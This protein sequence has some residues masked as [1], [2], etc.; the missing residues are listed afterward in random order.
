LLGAIVLMAWFLLPKLIRMPEPTEGPAVVLGMARPLTSTPLLEHHPRQFPDS[1]WVV[2]AVLRRD[3]GDWDLAR[4]SLVDGVS[5][6]L[7]AEP[8][9]SEYGAAI[10]PRGDSVAYTRLTADGC[11]VVTRPFPD[12][13]PSDVAFCTARLPTTVDWSPS[14]DELAYTAAGSSPATRQRRIHLYDT[15]S[16]TRRPLTVGVSATELDYF[17]RFSPDGRTLA[18]QRGELLPDMQS[19]LWTVDLATGEETQ[20]T[21]SPAALGGMSWIDEHTLLFT[22]RNA[23]SMRSR[24]IDVATGATRPIDA[25]AFMHPEYRREDRRLIAVAPRFDRDIAIIGADRDATLVAQS[26]SDDHSGRLSADERWIAFISRRSGHDELWISSTEGDTSRRLTNFS[27]ASVGSPD[28]SPDGSSILVTV[29]SESGE[30]LYAVDVSS[31]T[32]TPIETGFDDVTAPRWIEGGWVAGCRSNTDW[33]ICVSERGVVRRIADGFFF[34]HPGR[35]GNLYVVDAGGALFN[36]SI[37]DGSVTKILD[38]MPGDGRFG[39]EIDEGTLFFL[40]PG[41]AGHTGR[42]LQVD[43]GGGEPETLYTGAMP[44]AETS[45]SVGRASGR[46][47]LTLFQESGDDIVVFENLTFD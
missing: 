37:A 27:G 31:A 22:L 14:G 38:G 39:W 18:F 24:L 47:L 15:E 41:E 16:G 46:I 21:N 1:D 45:I 9:V 5:E 11:N 6:P 7:A 19:T 13:E 25:S 4:V 32:E 26:A 30:R 23:G 42:L 35:A 44:I 34:P 3:R 36:L 43:L 33:G 10:S 29:A 8:G 28:W 17:P 2:R 20:L 40:A 12:G